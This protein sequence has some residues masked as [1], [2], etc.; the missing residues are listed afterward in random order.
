MIDLAVETTPE[1]DPELR[2][3]VADAAPRLFAVVREPDNG[4]DAA[5]TAWGMAFT[6]GVEVIGVDNPVRLSMSTP[7]RACDLLADDDSTTWLIWSD[8]T[9]QPQP[10]PGAV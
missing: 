3:L 7:E 5:I 4:E 1:F 6:D 9:G 10:E 8:D 2:D